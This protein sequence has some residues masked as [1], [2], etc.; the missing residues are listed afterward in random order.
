MR[1]FGKYTRTGI[2]TICLMTAF[3]VGVWANDIDA[4]APPPINLPI[5]ETRVP[6]GDGQV[7][8][9]DWDGSRL[10]FVKVEAGSVH[11]DG[12]YFDVKGTDG[13]WSDSP[14]HH[15][16]GEYNMGYVN[17]GPPTGGGFFNDNHF[18]GCLFLIGWTVI[19]GGIGL[20]VAIRILWEFLP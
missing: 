2:K 10:E 4:L 3:M 16:R 14:Y 17:E 13:A 7:A 8:V 11:E 19:A 5:G 9:I 20:I 18:R 15:L 6:I 1:L 12:P